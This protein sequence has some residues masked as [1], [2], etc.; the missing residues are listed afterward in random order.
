[1]WAQAQDRPEAGASGEPAAWLNIPSCGIDTLVVRDASRENLH[2]FPC[3]TDPP[4]GV[5][6]CTN[7]GSNPAGGL[8]VIT[9]HRDT[10]FRALGCIA[11][12]DRIEITFPN[13][14]AR[15]FRVADTEILEPGEAAD[16]IARKRG[17]DGL[18]LMTCFPFRYIGP[19][20][21]RFVVWSKADT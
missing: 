14:G 4:P 11:P 3:V 10:H 18:V 16:R 21:K 15:H 13:R 19:A 9:A 5:A 1:M 6:P 2:R 20:P 8:L 12:G 17:E 7:P